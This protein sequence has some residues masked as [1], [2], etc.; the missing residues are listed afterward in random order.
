MILPKITNRPEETTPAAP[1]RGSALLPFTNPEQLDRIA[2]LFPKPNPPLKNTLSINTEDLKYLSYLIKI[3]H[4]IEG[5]W[6]YPALAAHAGIEG[7]LFLHFKI[8][9][10]GLVG[11]IDIIESSGYRFFDEEA[12]RAIRVSTPFAPLPEEWGEGNVT[13]TARFIY[14]NQGTYIR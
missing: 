10:E 11:P 2:R 7:E 14:H 12:I 3:K 4:Q 8:D 13:I 6:T 9:R 5:V 1:H